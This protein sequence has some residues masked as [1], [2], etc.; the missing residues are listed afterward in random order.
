M[1]TV[2][3]LLALVAVVGGCAKV[4]YFGESFAPTTQVD[5][6]FDDVDIE[7]EYRVIGRIYA[8]APSEQAFV[9]NEKLLQKIKEKAMENGGDAV[10][11]L[12]FAHVFA[13]ASSSTTETTKETDTGTTTTSHT[14]S[15]TEEKREIEALVI[16]YE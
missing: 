8:S 5:V 1:K 13:G 16:V 4:D 14:S 7:F 2:V 15:T 9:S 3:L 6:Y 10:I 11:I 12:G